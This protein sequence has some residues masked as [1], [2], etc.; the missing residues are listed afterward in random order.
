MALPLMRRSAPGARSSE[1][2]GRSP[3]D[4]CCSAEDEDDHDAPTDAD[5][6]APPTSYSM[7]F[8]ALRRSSRGLRPRLPLPLPPPP[9]LLES[10]E[11]S[12]PPPRRRRPEEDEPDEED[13]LRPHENIWIHTRGRSSHLNPEL[14]GSASEFELDF[15][16]AVAAQHLGRIGGEELRPSAACWEGGGVCRVPWRCGGK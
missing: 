2:E 12:A 3:G 1:R 15:A 4:R 16:A 14:H 13:C 10:M 8:A 9:R 6:P 7:R 11:A 5:A